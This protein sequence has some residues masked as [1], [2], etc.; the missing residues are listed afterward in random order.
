MKRPAAASIGRTKRHKIEKVHLPGKLPVTT[1]CGFLGAGKTT[2]LKH[3]LEVKHSAGQAFKCAVIVN[4]MAEINIDKNFIDQSALVQSNDVIAMQNG[5]VCC[6]LQDDLVSQ[7]TSLAKRRQFHYM[8]IEASGV[9]EPSQIAKLFADCEED[10]DHHEEHGREDSLKEF[11]NLDTCVTVVDSSDFF[12]KLRAVKRGPNNESFP[13]LLVEQVEYSNVIVLNKTDLLSPAQ[14]AKVVDQVS[15]L[16]TR[17]RVLTARNSKIDV[18]EVLNTNL[19]KADQFGTFHVEDDEPEDRYLASC[20]TDSISRGA[21]PC[22]SL[23]S[24]KRIIDSGKSRLILALD[25]SK[26]NVSTKLQPRHVDRFGITSFVYQARRPFHP[27]RFDQDFVEKFFVFQPKL[28][29]E[30]VQNV[31]TKGRRVGRK[32][33]EQR[34]A[35]RQKVAAIR[36]QQK[37]AAAKERLRSETMGDLLRSKGFLWLASRHDMIGMMN[38]ASSVTTIEFPSTWTVLRTESYEGTEEEKAALHKDWVAPWGDRR[39][40][41]V[42]IGK[43]LK[44]QAIQ[45]I[46]DS[47]L[48]TDA[49]MDLGIDGWK[50]TMGDALL[51]EALEGESD[52]E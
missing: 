13:Q 38:T 3:I 36:K 47:C 18:M 43:D 12:N 50:A 35:E 19:Y 41:F 27:E 4:D 34:K 44:H 33:E 32:S 28:E 26:L 7:I 31:K 8:I 14:L 46:L 42:F 17:A 5:C 16:N 51:H 21:L 39:Q 37:E 49:E 11:A 23:A 22:C 2:L 1:L 15:I 10:H 45:E 9:S 24:N 40:D 29:E 6:T 48:L 52:T 25:R 20:C 30:D